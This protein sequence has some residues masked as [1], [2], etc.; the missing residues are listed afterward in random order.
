[1]YGWAVPT[2]DWNECTDTQREVRKML[3]MG[4]Q[5]LPM[6]GMSVQTVTQREVRKMLCMGG[7]YLPMTG[8]SVQTVTQREVRKMLCISSCSS[9]RSSSR[10]DFS[11]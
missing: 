8:M 4:G 9:D 10:M 3:C 7:Q 11:D 2:Y 1:V 5:Y 6:T